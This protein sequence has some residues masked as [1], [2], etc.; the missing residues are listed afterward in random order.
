MTAVRDSVARPTRTALQLS[1]AAVVVE[2]VDAFGAG[3]DGR[4]YAAA[5]GL[6][7]LLLSFVQAVVE[8]RTGHAV[9]RN[10][11]ARPVPVVDD[12]PGAS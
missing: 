7:A 9:L 11:P 2:A 3:F 12:P 5:V 4:Q 1:A 8:Q 10:V 6:L